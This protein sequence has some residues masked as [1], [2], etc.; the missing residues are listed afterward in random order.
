MR[1]IQQQNCKNKTPLDHYWNTIETFFEIILKKID[2]NFKYPWNCLETPLKHSLNDTIWH[3]K[4]STDS[5]DN[6]REKKDTRRHWRTMSLLLIAAAP[7]LDKGYS[8]WNVIR[9]LPLKTTAPDYV[10]LLSFFRNW[11]T[12]FCIISGLQRSICYMQRQQ[13]RTKGLSL[14]TRKL[15][16][17]LIMER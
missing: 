2:T 10:D 6:K 5:K 13:H 17:M 12:G 16:P 9:T 3:S 8:G 15:V 7:C 1:S 4:W 11:T 14:L